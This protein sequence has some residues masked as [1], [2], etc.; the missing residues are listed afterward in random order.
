VKKGDEVKVISPG[1][2]FDEQWCQVI[3]ITGDK[4]VVI[5]YDCYR[6]KIPTS[7]ILGRKQDMLEQCNCEQALNY[8][9][10]AKDLSIKIL[11]YCNR[12]E[13]NNSEYLDSE[14]VPAANHIIKTAEEE[15]EYIKL[16][17]E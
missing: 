4:E 12:E 15:D 6:Y 2:P 8:K 9:K 14:I 16:G 5:E 3:M 11:D 1:D 10:L 13:F 17:D 7:K